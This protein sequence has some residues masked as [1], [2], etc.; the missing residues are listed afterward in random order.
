MRKSHANLTFTVLIFFLLFSSVEPLFADKTPAQPSETPQTSKQKKLSLQ[1]NLVKAAGKGDLETV[2]TLLDVGADINGSPSNSNLT[3]LLAAIT[4]KQV[5]TVAYL[6][7]RGAD[8]NKGRSPYSSPLNTANFAGDIT[9]H[10]LLLDHGVRLDSQDY[11]GRIPFL[12]AISFAHRTNLDII[13]LFVK[14]GAR[15][16]FRDKG[17]WT[18]LHFAASAPMKGLVPWLLDMGLSPNAVDENGKTPLH[19][20]ATDYRYDKAL[21]LI[22]RG[23]DIHARDNWNQTPLYLAAHHKSPRL[24][25]KLIALGADVNVPDIFGRTPLYMAQ[26]LPKEDGKK[27]NRISYWT[28]GQRESD[29]RI[30]KNE[31]EEIIRLLKQHGAEDHGPNQPVPK[32]DHDISHFCFTANRNAG[33]TPAK[34]KNLDSTPLHLAAE[35]G[36]MDRVGQ[37]LKQGADPHARDEYQR[38]ALHYASTNG[39]TAMASLLLKHGAKLEVFDEYHRNPLILAVKRCRIETVELL[40]K[41]GAD[42]N[43]RD[44]KEQSSFYWATEKRHS[45]LTFLLYSRGAQLKK[46]HEIGNLLSW[47]DLELFRVIVGKT[48]VATLKRDIPGLLMGAAL[49]GREDLVRYLIDY[50]LDPGLQWK[51]RHQGVWSS[52]DFMDTPLHGAMR[53]GNLAVVK[54]LV[55]R[56]AGIDLQDSNKRTPLFWA[57]VYAYEDIVRY[58]IGQGAKVY[59]EAP[60]KSNGLH[61]LVGGYFEVG[62][63]AGLGLAFVNPIPLAELFLAK[64]AKINGRDRAQKTPL[65]LAIEF[66]REAMVKWLLDHNADPNLPSNDGRTPL[67]WAVQNANPAMVE[68]LMQHGANPYIKNKYRDTPLE[69]AI[70][71]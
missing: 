46:G 69:D 54:L 39:D 13:K 31:R 29:L 6:L 52:F 49:Q 60:G 26:P 56:G 23:A 61:W 55:E 63:D 2:K 48:P 22:K 33:P 70:E 47:A 19:R 21:I 30:R 65:F 14:H 68:L 66:H 34:I 17:G 7:Q 67:H 1:T 5:K 41:H 40:L 50:S 9:I 58:L 71:R 10:R 43:A 62:N 18:A 27:N 3:P 24:V 64:G 57:T 28:S 37:L 12:D 8:P 35:W 59:L 15:L 16:H 42:I 36:D 20:A 38:T 25:K 11:H 45:K 32:Y 44:D 53:S 4:E 51:R